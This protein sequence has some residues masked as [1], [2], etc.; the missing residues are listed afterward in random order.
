MIFL[1]RRGYSPDMV[2]SDVVI[3]AD[4]VRFIATVLA[5]S[6]KKDRAEAA[7]AAL[8]AKAESDRSSS[9]RTHHHHPGQSQ[10]LE[11]ALHEVTTL[12]SKLQAE[13]LRH[14]QQVQQLKEK[15][16]EGEKKARRES[17]RAL[18]AYMKSAVHALHRLQKD[19]DE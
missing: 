5:E 1:G 7:S 3:S 8:S 2:T 13:R 14:Q 10:E 4:H 17:E 6:R 12:E 15:A 11:D 16:V 9:G 18:R 19:D